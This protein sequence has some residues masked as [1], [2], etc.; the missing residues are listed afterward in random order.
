MKAGD[1]LIQNFLRVTPKRALDA[2][3][4]PLK[5]KKEE[6]Q[7]FSVKSLSK[8]VTEIL[9][10]GCHGAFLGISFELT[11]ANVQAL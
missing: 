1:F 11:Y 9:K 7:V 3:D 2:R 10:N 5:W 8:Q 6:N 4:L